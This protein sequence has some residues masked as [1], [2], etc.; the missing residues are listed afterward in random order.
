[1][2]RLPIHGLVVLQCRVEEDGCIEGYLHYIMYRNVGYVGSGPVVRSGPVV[3]FGP[4]VRSGP[5]VGSEPVVR[6]GLVVGSGPV[7]S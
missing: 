5:V 3:G 4:V 1:M 2:N 7:H 6:S